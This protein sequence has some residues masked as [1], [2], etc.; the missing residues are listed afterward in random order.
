MQG[1]YFDNGSTS[2]P[3]APGVSDAVKALLD[4]GAFNI[5]RGGYAGAYAVAESV[6][7]TRQQ[8]AELFHFENGKQVIFTPSVTYSLNYLLKGLLRSGDH[9]IV[10]SM[11]HNAVMRPLVQLEREGITVSV[12]EADERGVLDPARVEALVTPKTRLVVMTC[13]SNVCGTMLPIKEVGEICH[14]HHIYFIADTAQMAGVLPIDGEECHLDAIA[15]TGHKSLLGPQGIGGFLIRDALVPLV[16]PLIAGGTGSLSDSEEMPDFLP[17][18]YEAGTMNLPGIIGLHAALDYVIPNMG[19]IHAHEME[20]TAAFLA[21]ARELPDTRI[22]GMPDT[23]GRLAMVSLDFPKQDN[24]EI[25][26]RLE[27]EYG[28]MTRCG[29]HC[30]P[31]AHRT[32]GTY[33]Q[34]TVR[35]AFSRASTLDE[36]EACMQALHTILEG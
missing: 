23:A 35:F 34:G 20:I 30:A 4:N 15:F 18:R 9:V 14:R 12:A 33:P 29:L 36:V 10:S 22:V 8:L 31:R 3:K 13:A 6:F 7:S 28:I 27:N 25:A 11:E 1:I 2:F 32:L 21:G 19:K 24:A 16:T 26:F 17:D 5:N